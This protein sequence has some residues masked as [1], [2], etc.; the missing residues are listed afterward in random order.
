VIAVRE[1][2]SDGLI[3]EEN[4]GVFIPAVLEDLWPILIF[5]PARA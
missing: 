4:V 2:N 3:H 1:A 5:N